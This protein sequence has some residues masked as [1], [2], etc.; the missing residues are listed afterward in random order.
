MMPTFKNFSGGLEDSPA[1]VPEEGWDSPL[2]NFFFY[3]WAWKN[4]CFLRNIKKVKKK[5]E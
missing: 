2:R 4:L 3:V 1:P 5:F